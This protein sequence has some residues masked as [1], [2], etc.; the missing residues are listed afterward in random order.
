MNRRSFLRL[1]GAGAGGMLGALAGCGVAGGG[2]TPVR[3]WSAENPLRIPPELEPHGPGRAYD[4]E[5]R[6][7]RTAFLA[8]RPTSTWGVNGGYLGPTLRMRHGDHVT[9]NVQNN[10]PEATTLH[11]H[12][13]RLP[14]AADGGPHQSIPAIGRWQPSWDVVNAA[15]TS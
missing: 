14:A 4:L 7:G 5:L 13:M 8:G 12:G 9:V 2:D 15:S 3:E 10:L 6:P 1:V 11:W